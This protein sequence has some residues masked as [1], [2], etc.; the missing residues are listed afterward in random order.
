MSRVRHAVSR[1]SV[2]VVLAV[3]AWAGI[4]RPLAAAADG[5]GAGP[6]AAP[7]LP[8]AAGSVAGLTG[9]SCTSASACTA[10]GSTEL[11]TLAERWNGRRWAIQ[12]TPSP[13]SGTALTAVSCAAPDMCLAVGSSGN[14]NP[15]ATLAELWNGHRWTVR[16]PV[17]PPHRHAGLLGV[18][19]PAVTTCLAVGGY[20]D[21][22]AVAELWNGTRWALQRVPRVRGAQITLL[23]SVSCTSPAACTAVGSY[24]GPNAVGVVADRW[25]GTAWAIQATAPDSDLRGVSCAKVTACTA[26]G[27]SQPATGYEVPV[28]MQWNGTRWARQH[29]VNPAHNAGTELESVSCPSA[30]AC[31]AVGNYYRASGKGGYVTLAERWNGTTWALSPTPSTRG[32]AS[33]LTGV[34]CS[35]AAACMAVG[36]GFGGPLTERWNGV[37]WVVVPAPSPRP[38]PVPGSGELTGVSCT[39]PADCTA[40]G[41]ELTTAFTAQA[42]IAEHWDGSRWTAQR[43]PNPV[44]VGDGSEL[45]AV[46]CTSGRACT[47]VGVRGSGVSATL[48]ERWTGRRWVVQPT[49]N[50][51]ANDTSPGNDTG[52]AGVA[53]TSARWCTAAGL[54]IT[55]RGLLLTLAEHWN[56]TRWERQHTPSPPVGPG[57]GGGVLNAIGCS[58]AAACTA[59]GAGEIVPPVLERWNGATWVMQHSPRV[60]HPGPGELTSVSCPAA[61]VCLAAGD[62]GG[63]DT[64]FSA[65]ALAERWTGKVWVSQRLPEPPGTTDSYLNGISCSSPVAC[66]AVGVSF[67]SSSRG[68]ILAERWNGKTWAIQ[69]TPVPPGYDSVFYAVSCPSATACVAVGHGRSGPLAARWNGRTWTLLRTPGQASRCATEPCICAFTLSPVRAFQRSDQ[70]VRGSGLGVAHAR[71]RPGQE[72][73]ASAISCRARASSEGV[74]ST[75]TP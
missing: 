16:L 48:A 61:A 43:I 58:S 51:G 52:L 62:T 29:P 24:A 3:T 30:A 55:P 47:A 65:H 37:R 23:E 27:S 73:S 54:H 1:V 41:S 21:G 34:S 22:L 14:P 13:G 20:S 6:P 72:V 4:T 12:H 10:V 32:G 33:F 69:K 40:V 50:P 35:S 38:V 63:S 75:R 15:R 57:V 5:P 11:G 46:A 18:D 8:A 53:C 31:I 70:V 26:V 25:N 67:N 9:V 42:P 17:T 19:C 49:P 39:A 64:N 7:G 68:L 66:T 36:S 71:H 2:A 60:R 56:G 74:T 28:A 44:Y 59:V 45:S